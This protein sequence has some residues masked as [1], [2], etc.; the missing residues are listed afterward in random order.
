[1]VAHL[2]KD[3]QLIS[4]QLFGS[5]SQQEEKVM[6]LTRALDGGK[7]SNDAPKKE[8]FLC[9]TGGCTRRCYHRCDSMTTSLY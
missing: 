8:R 3:R 1:M 2:D 4:E 5:G 7:S 9:V 6:I